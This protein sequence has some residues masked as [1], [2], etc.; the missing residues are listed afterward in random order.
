MCACCTK[1]HA[2]SLLWCLLQ[3]PSMPASIVALCCYTAV[4]IALLLMTIKTRGWFMI[5][6]VIT[7]ALEALGFV[8]R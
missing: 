5:T 6:A 7:G 2:C 1:A 8:A 3:V 4:T